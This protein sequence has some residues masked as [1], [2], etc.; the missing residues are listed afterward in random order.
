MPAVMGFFRQQNVYLLFLSSIFAVVVKI[1]KGNYEFHN[2]Q[3]F[4][5]SPFSCSFWSASADDILGGYKR[6]MPLSKVFRPT[7][8]LNHR[9]C[10]SFA[11]SFSPMISQMGR[12]QQKRLPKN[13]KTGTLLLHRKENYASTSSSIST[14]G[15]L[16]KTRL[17]SLFDNNNNNNNGNEESNNK[18]SKNNSRKD[19]NLSEDE[20]NEFDQDLYRALQGLNLSDD[21]MEDL[22]KTKRKK[23]KKK[24]SN[25]R[26]SRLDDRNPLQ[27]FDLIE[28]VKA[29]LDVDPEPGKR[30][31]AQLTIISISLLS[32][33]FLLTFFL[34][35][36][37]GLLS[38]TTF[39]DASNPRNPANHI[40]IER[41][42][43][44]SRE[45]E[46]GNSD[47]KNGKS[48]TVVKKGEDTTPRVGTKTFIDPNDLMRQ[49][50]EKSIEEKGGSYFYEY[51]DTYKRL[52]NDYN[53]KPSSSP[54]NNNGNKESDMEKTSSIETKTSAS[55]NYSGNR[56]DT[57][58]KSNELENKGKVNRVYQNGGKIVP[59]ESDDTVI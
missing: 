37:Q 10:S 33:S 48:K 19:N 7:C 23:T 25:P 24:M 38:S 36:P 49:E 54:R 55:N 59:I 4:P 39:S 46:E 32:F 40:A 42:Q 50:F 12:Y 6:N 31:D 57:E 5:S 22:M 11:F 28:S 17:S 27:N 53:V 14:Y 20:I 56:I 26:P 13:M 29:I 45:L 3:S 9:R 52:P 47:N 2:S 16:P 51:P 44:E 34:L 21:P 1:T 35:V 8:S 41:M 18:E 15:S 30:R 58:S 43:D